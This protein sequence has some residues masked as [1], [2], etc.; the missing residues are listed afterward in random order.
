MVEA[1]CLHCNVVETWDHIIKC[2][3]TASIRREFVKELVSELIKNKP[4]EVS[5]DL[6]M[7]FV[8]DALMCLDDKDKDEC[9][10]N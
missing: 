5:A 6:I 8:E 1:N 10:T 2:K 7:S 9:E 3:E 4:Q